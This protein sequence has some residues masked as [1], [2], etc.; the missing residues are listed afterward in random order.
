VAWGI[1]EHRPPAE[2]AASSDKTFG[3]G[4]FFGIVAMLEQEMTTGSFVTKSK[5]RL[6]KLHRED[7]HRLE[8]ASPEIGSYLRR[9]ARERREANARLAAASEV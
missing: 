6:L 3:R 5:C 4:D 7:F 9:K 1:V 2:A 8:I